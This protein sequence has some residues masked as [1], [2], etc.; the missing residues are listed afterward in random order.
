MS[1]DVDDRPPPP[2]PA[3]PPPLIVPP[4]LVPR[5]PRVK[6]E[7]DRPPKRPKPARSS[8][9]EFLGFASGLLSLSLI[10]GM[11]ALVGFW[12]VRY[13]LE[14]PGPLQ[15]DTVVN[16]LRG[17]SGEAVAET[18]TR[19]GVI[20]DGQVFQIANFIESRRFGGGPQ[21]GEY[22]IPKGATM[23]QVLDIVRSGKVVQYAVTIPEGLTS[24]QVV[25]RLREA[26]VLNMNVPVGQIPP[27]GTLLPQTYNVPRGFSAMDLLR[28]MQADQR[29][30]VDDIWKRRNPSLPLR[31]PEELVILASI[32]EKET[33]KADERP[34]VA[35]VFVN[36]LIKKIRLQSDPTTIYGLVGGQGSLGR[37]LT[38]SEIDKPTPYNTYIIPALPPTPIANPG[39]EALEAVANPARGNDLYFVADGTGGHTFS[40]TYEQHQR[41]VARWR[42]IERARG[43]TISPGID[44]PPAPAPTRP[45]QPRVAPLPAPGSPSATNLPP[46][47][48]PRPAA[49][50]PPLSLQPQQ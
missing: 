35:A 41:A 40:E 3:P 36:R 34:R 15:A 10:V 2:E 8:T 24:L 7:P 14:E 27:E 19:S 44:A 9:K 6:I 32:V 42:D 5:S 47:V 22:L 37:G 28:R 49:P 18:L 33:G 16:I 13:A 46:A 12:S 38:R 50:A 17:S 30:L 23:Q 11:L 21:A 26:G 25:Q 4:R 31:T 29:K 43:N 48:Q 20:R 45:P 1:H 39:K